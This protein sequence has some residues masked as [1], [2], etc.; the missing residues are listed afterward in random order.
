MRPDG[1]NPA[2]LIAWACDADVNPDQG[3][4]MPAKCLVHDT[5]GWE[6]CGI[7]GVNTASAA[8][9]GT[10]RFMSEDLL[11][12]GEYRKHAKALRAA[13]KFDR[14]AK[15]SLILK[16]IA[17]DY[18]QMAK[19]LEGARPSATSPHDRPDGQSESAAKQK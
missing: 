1:A 5:M 13:A 7:S 19:A 14:E 8:V 4:P 15:T 10:S 11:L 16:R 18:E 6:R 3:P 17:E 2:L 12:A 9:C